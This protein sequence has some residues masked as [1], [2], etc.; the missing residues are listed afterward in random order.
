MGNEKS[1]PSGLLI[2]EKAFS[3]NNFWTLHGAS[4][5]SALLK[6]VTVFIGIADGK[7]LCALENLSKVMLIYNNN[8]LLMCTCIF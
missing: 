4:Y 5:G 6:K 1:H 7:K 2:E 3:S 8:R